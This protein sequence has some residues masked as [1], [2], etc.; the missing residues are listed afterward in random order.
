MNIE[1]ATKVLQQSG[2]GTFKAMGPVLDGYGPYVKKWIVYQPWLNH[3]NIDEV[4]RKMTRR[5][6]R[7][8]VNKDRL[9][10]IKQSL[11]NCNHKSG[12]VWEAG[13]YQ[14]GSASLICQLLRKDSKNQTAVR[15]FD[16][17]EGMPVTDKSHDLHKKGDFGD[18]S[19]EA[20]RSLVGDDDFIK[21]HPGLVPETFL[22][23]EKSVIKFA[24]I[25]LDIYHPIKASC[26]FIWPRLIQG[27]VIIFDDYGFSTCPGAREAVDGFF[28]KI[29]MQPLVLPTGTAIIYKI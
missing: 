18:T 12:E 13:V 2:Y 22:G 16:T 17:F 6:V 24:H 19:L 11:S 20:V 4:V 26:E 27:G 1:E 21:Y 29:G 5:N 10:I 14:G 9:H 23:L 8:L 7:S 25:D 3:G 15:L 28:Q